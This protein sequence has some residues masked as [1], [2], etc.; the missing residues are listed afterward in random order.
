MPNS[1]RNGGATEDG[2]VVP[3]N[4]TCGFFPVQYAPATAF[5]NTVDLFRYSPAPCIQACLMPSHACCSATITNNPC[6][7]AAR[8][9]DPIF[10]RHY[11]LA[12]LAHCW[13]T[14]AV[15]KTHGMHPPP[16]PH[17]ASLYQASSPQ[18]GARPAPPAPKPLRASSRALVGLPAPCTAPPTAA[19]FVRPVEDRAT[20]ISFSPPMNRYLTKYTTV[21]GVGESEYAG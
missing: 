5:P 3:L 10:K 4:T 1:K 15:A 14:C 9:L 19:T 18:R 6:Q 12:S 13:S 2:C 7:I 17:T 20:R 16:H 11:S 21:P 8:P